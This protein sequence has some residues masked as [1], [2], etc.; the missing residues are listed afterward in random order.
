MIKDDNTMNVYCKFYICQLKSSTPYSIY[1]PKI[2]E[3]LNNLRK[4][5]EPTPLKQNPIEDFP[6][7]SIENITIPNNNNN[8]I[9]ILYNSSMVSKDEEGRNLNYLAQTLQ[10][11]ENI[12][13][14][15]K[16]DDNYMKHIIVFENKFYSRVN[17]LGIVYQ[18][19]TFSKDNDN[20]RHLLKV[21]DGTGR[22]VIAFFEKSKF[23][24][25][26]NA[27]IQN[28]I[29][30][31]M[32][33]NIFGRVTLYN[34]DIQ[35][36]GEKYSLVNHYYIE[37]LFNEILIQEQRTLNILKSK[38][39]NSGD[40]NNLLKKIKEKYY[41]PYNIKLEKNNTMNNNINNKPGTKLI[42]RIK[43]NN[44]LIEDDGTCV[45]NNN[46]N[47]SNNLITN[48]I[49]NN[50][51]SNSPTFEYNVRKFA[52]YL[53]LVL[54]EKDLIESNNLKYIVN[55]EKDNEN[56]NNAIIKEDIMEIET[57]LQKEGN[58]IPNNNEIDDKISASDIINKKNNNIENINNLNTNNNIEANEKLY[59]K[60][61]IIEEEIKN[62]NSRSE[63]MD[64]REKDE[65][66]QENIDEIL[67]EDFLNFINEQEKSKQINFDK[68]EFPLKINP[69]PKKDAKYLIIKLKYLLSD[70]RIY[71]LMKHY[72]PSIDENDPS[73]IIPVFKIIINK[74]EQ[75]VIGKNITK[76]SDDEYLEN[77]VEFNVRFID[78]LKEDIRNII[79]KKNGEKI[80]FYDIKHIIGKKYNQLILDKIIKLLLQSL[81]NSCEI[82]MEDR[83]V[84]RYSMS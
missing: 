79:K 23:V 59:N 28:D 21:D 6:N 36:T 18:M 35:I 50:K 11:Y 13:F 77:E 72:I 81:V 7:N 25:K 62:D 4:E 33:I 58:N 40:D 27:D 24:K 66:K 12:D 29:K 45:I 48:N 30:T 83:H 69:N 34:G 43:N 54:D 38:N 10:Q 71:S 57:E 51:I 22:M 20:K 1:L 41:T 82:Y 70:I 5:I 42:L 68:E 73:T 31:G 67:D 8:S 2:K 84:Y 49:N 76:L 74:L 52:N 46:I 15:R 17:I 63:Y 3:E 14:E 44:G 75:N 65:E 26:Y 9:S 19:D 39:N 64:N 61:N 32:K 37:N 78:K 55:D 80:T 60:D 56:E 47:G 53:L 16:V